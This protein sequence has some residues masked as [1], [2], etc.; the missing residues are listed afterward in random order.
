VAEI[1]P[2]IALMIARPFRHP[3]GSIQKLGGI[4][5]ALSAIAEQSPGYSIVVLVDCDDDCPKEMGP[6]MAGERQRRVRIY[7]SL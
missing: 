1:D 7:L 6:R 5:R 3:A 2:G 4:E